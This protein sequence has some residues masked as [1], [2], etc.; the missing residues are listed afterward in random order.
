MAKADETQGAGGTAIVTLV[1]YSG[2]ENPSWVLPAAA[3]AALARRLQ[4][5]APAAA[6]ARPPSGLGYRGV[7]VRLPGPAGDTVA[8][9]GGGVVVIAADGTERHLLDE[10]RAIERDLV[11]GGLGGV[12]PAV[13]NAIEHDLGPAR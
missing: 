10:G 2:R 1:V 7:T 8:T 6:D 9:I 5:L 11:G 13:R 3:A 4:T 12:S